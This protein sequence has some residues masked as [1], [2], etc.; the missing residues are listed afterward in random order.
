MAN[1]GLAK[2]FQPKFEILICPNNK[3]ECIPQLPVIN[4]YFNESQ[5]YFLDK[6]YKHSIENLRQ[7]YAI[8]FEIKDPACLKCAD[9]FRANIISS[10]ENI[11]SELQR[12]TSGW[13]KARRYQSSLE[14]V[15]QVLK[16]YKTGP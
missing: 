3:K 1:K 16:E 5:L 14:L 11:H 4:Q 10:L 8:T 6:D 2:D 13:F 7:A 15:I 9:V 12:L